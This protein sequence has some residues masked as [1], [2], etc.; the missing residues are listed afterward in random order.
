MPKARV[1]QINPA[2]TAARA[3]LLRLRLVADGIGICCTTLSQNKNAVLQRVAGHAGDVIGCGQS[4]R[5][6]RGVS[7]PKEARIAAD[8]LGRAQPDLATERPGAVDRA[9]E[10]GQIVDGRATVVVD[11]DPVIDNPVDGVVR[12]ISPR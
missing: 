1:A 7:S 5:D 2:L 12:K 10:Q 6:S 4:P 3:L 11:P 9:R 8:V